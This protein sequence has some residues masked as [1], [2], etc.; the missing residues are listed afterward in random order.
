MEKLL[1]AAMDCSGGVYIAKL[2]CVS[3]K[4]VETGLDSDSSYC[5]RR[6]AESLLPAVIFCNQ[7]QKAWGIKKAT[8]RERES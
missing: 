4:T 1:A 5:M 7:F 2:S 6:I 8:E 3:K